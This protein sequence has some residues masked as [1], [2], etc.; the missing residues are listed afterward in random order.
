MF[1]GLFVFARLAKE[2]LPE[3]ANVM[4]TLG[5]VYY[6]KGF[7]DNAIAEFRGS[8]EKLPE[9]A[10]VHYHLGMAYYKKGESDR[11]REALEEALSLDANFDH[12][13]EAR[14]VLAEL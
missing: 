13:D 5:L 6:K 1:P 8:L 11:A 12:A 10:T 9:N 3:D 14:K 2:A 4:D 7:H